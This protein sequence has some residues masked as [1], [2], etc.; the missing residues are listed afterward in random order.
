ARTTIFQIPY[1]TTNQSDPLTMASRSAPWLKPLTT[2]S[3]RSGWTRLLGA[4]P[5]LISDPTLRFVP[6]YTFVSDCY[7]MP[8]RSAVA[9]KIN[10][11]RGDNDREARK[12]CSAVN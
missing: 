7:R 9:D 2:N 3:L 8:V 5:S 12:G 11:Q 4:R 10:N 1:F 6:R